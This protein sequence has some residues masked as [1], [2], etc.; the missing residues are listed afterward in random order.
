MTQEIVQ[1]VMQCSQQ[2]RDNMAAM[3]LSDQDILMSLC[4]ATIAKMEMMDRQPVGACRANMA[5]KCVTDIQDYVMMSHTPH[6]VLCRYVL[7][8]IWPA[9][10]LNV[11]ELLKGL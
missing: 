3:F 9:Q 2:H 7:V 5:Q 10:V 4:G 11:L 1:E 8:Y 6:D